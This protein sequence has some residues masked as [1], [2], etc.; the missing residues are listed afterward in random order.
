M[1]VDSGPGQVQRCASGNDQLK[2]S[3]SLAGDMDSV[4][5]AYPPLFSFASINSSGTSVHLF[6]GTNN[7]TG[8][9]TGVPDPELYLCEPMVAKKGN[10]KEGEKDEGNNII[11]GRKEGRGRN[12]EQEKGQK[13]IVER[14]MKL[15]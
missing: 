14:R 13:R 1:G 3:N 10:G 11:M 8:P 12:Q 6:S 7:S 4:G 15:L 5:D 2:V 9:F